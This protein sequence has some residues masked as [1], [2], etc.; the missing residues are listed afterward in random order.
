MLSVLLITAAACSSSGEKEQAS[1]LNTT[2]ES[3][4]SL[5]YSSDKYLIEAPEVK[6]MIDEGADD[7]ALIEVSKSDAYASG[8]IPG[9]LNI[10]RPMYENRSDYSYGGMM[11][12]KEQMQELLTR[13]GIR[14]ETN[15]IIYDVKGNVD[16]S[17]FMWILRSYGHEKIKLINGGK[18]GWQDAG[19]ALSTEPVEMV[20]AATPYT[21]DDRKAYKTISASQKDVLNAINDPDVILLDTRTLDEYTGKMLKNGAAK[22]GRIPGSIHVDWA[23]A[24]DYDK[25]FRF[26]TVEELRNLYEAKGI[27]KDKKVIAYCH[28]GVRSAHTQ[29]VLSELLGYENVINYDG[30]WTEWSHSDELPFEIDPA[31][32]LVGTPAAD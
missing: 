13:L 4:S 12:T 9:A 31:E 25:T 24:V 3:E 19:F 17:R 15:I 5:T 20:A 23:N 10:W 8:H 16:A 18:K 14:P 28:T 22:A 32:E 1:L 2:E 7:I 26:K 29:F 27:T 6:K 30:S 21:F 11:A